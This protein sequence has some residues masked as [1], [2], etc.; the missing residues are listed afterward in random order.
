VACFA[1]LR[2]SGRRWSESRTRWTTRTAG[3]PDLRQRQE[4]TPTGSVPSG[5]AHP[6]DGV[7][8]WCI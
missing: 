1:Y 2:M 3:R 4:E 8:G 6:L 5:V 7:T